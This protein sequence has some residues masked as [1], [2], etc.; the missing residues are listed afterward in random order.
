M[1]QPELPEDYKEYLRNVNVVAQLADLKL[2][3]WRRW[4]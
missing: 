1:E 2:D 4:D 3:D